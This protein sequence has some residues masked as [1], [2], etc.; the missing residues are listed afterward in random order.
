M[1]EKPTQLFNQEQPA[2]DPNFDPS[3]GNP[4]V[5]K[6]L[7]GDDFDQAVR[8][9]KQNF[10]DNSD[11][12]KSDEAVRQVVSGYPTGEAG[13]IINEPDIRPSKSPAAKVV[14]AVLGLGAVIG[15]GYLANEALSGPEISD[16]TQ[17]V[18]IEEGDTLHQIVNDHVEGA[19]NVDIRDV[20]DHIKNDPENAT[21]F[22]D[23]TTGKITS[24]IYPGETIEVPK[25]VSN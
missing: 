23:E 12:S 17:T 25:S 13:G 9:S 20:V 2:K 6:R 15:T 3:E 16:E 11:A 14:G 5:G 7:D 21:V 24:D 18:V 1:S 8:I 10:N 4:F 19:E 22:V